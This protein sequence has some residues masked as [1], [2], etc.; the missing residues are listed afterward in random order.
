MYKESDTSIP[1]GSM[2]A[3]VLH[4]ALQ[5]G[6]LDAD[7]IVYLLN[8]H[9]HDQLQELYAAARSIRE[10]TFQDNIYL[11]GFLYVSTY[12]RNDCAFCYFRKG[13]T[14]CTRYRKTA[15]E[16]INAARLLHQSGVHLLDLTMGE[17]PYFHDQARGTQALL[18]MLDNVRSA[19][20]LPL[21]VSPGVV[22]PQVLQ[23]LKSAGVSWYAC[24]QETYSQDLFQ[25]LRCGQSFSQRLAAKRQARDLGLLTEE[26]ILCGVGEETGDLAHSVLEMSRMGFDQV[27]AMT[28]IPQA[29]T[30]MEQH[31]GEQP[32]LELKLIAILRMLNP[33]KLIPASLDVSGIKGLQE[34]L[35]AGANVVTSIVPPGCGL[36]G[37]ANHD[38]DIENF[39]RTV[40]R[41]AAQIDSLG[42]HI[43]SLDSYVHWMHASSSS[44][45][46][47]AHAQ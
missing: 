39:N 40:D 22:P 12:C 8:I 16:I 29:G 30:P 25:G 18:A 36:S 37:V 43:G 7:D 21:M 1:D 31:A 47:E 5:G 23:D 42:L 11:Y 4:K 9:E 33:T 2:F 13:N 6:G 45:A 15:E 28:F 44:P 27:R 38:L 41:I 19:S 17:D 3:S 24:Y 20:S 14:Q 26:G 32:D 10:A 35:N 34:R 46:G